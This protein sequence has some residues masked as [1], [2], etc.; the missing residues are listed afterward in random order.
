MTM[1]RTRGGLAAML[2]ASSAFADVALPRPMNLPPPS[3][4]RSVID[5]A[6]N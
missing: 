5:I 6:T 1:R 3:S 4:E 2:I